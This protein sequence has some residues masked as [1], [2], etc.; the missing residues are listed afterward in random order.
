M[1]ER[2]EEI[3]KDSYLTLLFSI[4]AENKL[5]KKTTSL[6]KQRQLSKRLNFA[7][8]HLLQTEIASERKINA[9]TGSKSTRECWSVKL[10]QS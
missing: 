7:L 1:K 9:Q 6:K 3:K 10:N 5:F 4:L 8:L 2:L